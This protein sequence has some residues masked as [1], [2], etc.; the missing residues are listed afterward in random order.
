MHLCQKNHCLLERKKNASAIPFQLTI[1]F[2]SIIHP[3]MKI[4]RALRRDKLNAEGLA[5]VRLV[6]SWEGKRLG[7]GCLVKP[8][9]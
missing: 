2:L 9:H 7:T 8:E 3:K 6:V 5:P 1:Q 4:S